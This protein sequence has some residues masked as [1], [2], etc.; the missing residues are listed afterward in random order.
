MAKSSSRKVTSRKVAT[1]ASKALK[2]RRTSKTTKSIAAS[3][4]SQARG[5]K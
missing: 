2:D 1:K 4:L 5:R 3:A